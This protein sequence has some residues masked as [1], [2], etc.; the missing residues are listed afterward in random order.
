MG[1]VALRLDAGDTLLEA[2]RFAVGV[3]AYAAT[4]PGAQASYPTTSDLES[5]LRP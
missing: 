2:A 3:G 1:A 5:F 4:K